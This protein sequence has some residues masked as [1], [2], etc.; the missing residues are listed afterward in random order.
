MPSLSVVMIVKNEAE[1]LGECLESVRGIADELVI[2]DTGSTDD[3]VSVAQRFGAVVFEIPWTDDFAEA[4]NRGMARATGDR[5]G[6][7]R[8]GAPK[9]VARTMLENGPAKD[10]IAAP[11]RGP[12]RRRIGLTGTGL[13]HP[14]PK[15]VNELTKIMR[16]PMGSKWAMGL[17]VIRP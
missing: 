4:R 12:K 13:P 5:P 8:S 9:S 15:P 11:T 6:T 7:T 2:A 16:P 14:K 17:S 10:V 3:T 1:C